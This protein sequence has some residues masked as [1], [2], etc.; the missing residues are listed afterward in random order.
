MPPEPGVDV[1]EAQRPRLLRL[2][3]RMLGSSSEAE[4]VVQE[5]W[6]RWDR[7]AQAEIGEPAAWLT[8]VVSRLCLDMMKSARSRRESYPGIWLPEPLV[9]AEDDDLRA[10]NLTL[11]L[12]LALERLSPL[13]RAAFLLHD[14]FGQPLDEVAA[15]VERSPEAARQLARRAR[16]HVRVDQ[17]RYP[18]ARDEGENI[19]R[20][21]FEAC[22]VGDAEALS[23]MLAEG[24]TLQ[25][26]GGGK[27]LAY[28]NLIRGSKRMLRLLLGH[29]SKY[30]SGMRFE[31]FVMI[32]GLPGF[33]SAMGGQVQT[34]ALDTEGGK[35][36]AI[37]ITR[38]PE[39]LARVVH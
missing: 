11:T 15:V 14:V 8:R 24:V 36:T 39:K 13:E 25:S 10:D 32:D 35:I 34:T 9:E 37:Y 38:N 4:D 29:A 1:F 22:R 7:Q 26:D 31:R 27:V 30:G 23:R 5:A 17:L 20:A 18:V 16:A 2:A 12:M 19:V 28:P 33:V 6:L 21:F 3:Y